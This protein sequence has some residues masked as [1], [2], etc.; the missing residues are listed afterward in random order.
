MGKNSAIIIL[1]T[2]LILIPALWFFP[3]IPNEDGDVPSGQSDT[4]QPVVVLELFTS[5]GCSSCPPAD[6]LLHQLVSDSPQALYAV[7]YHVD[8]WNYI[9]WEDPFSK[10]EFT[11]MQRR[12][13]D[14]LHSRSNYT[15]ELIINGQEHMVGSDGARIKSRIRDYGNVAATNSVLLSEVKWD[16][17][18]IRAQYS[19]NGDLAGKQIKAVL[20]L[21]ERV[22]QVK[23]GENRGRTLLNSQIA[24][25]VREEPLSGPQGS[26]HFDA[27]GLLAPG[28]SIF[29]L[30]MTQNREYHITGAARTRVPGKS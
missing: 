29:L 16:D 7:S 15:P 5:Q 13:N 1:V 17:R 28:E 30:V 2:G 25:A 11:A 21:G 19:V 10:S 18:G 6:M 14:K 12:Y 24:L 22:T 26:L 20:V 9:G 27:P 23:R 8:Y 3:R 4:F